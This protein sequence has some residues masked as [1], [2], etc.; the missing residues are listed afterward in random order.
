MDL[1]VAA[2]TLAAFERQHRV[3]PTAR[4]VSEADQAEALVSPL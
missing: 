4:G 1:A 2:I 3:Q